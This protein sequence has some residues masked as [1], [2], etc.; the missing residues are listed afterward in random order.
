MGEPRR[1]LYGKIVNKSVG[2]EA[3]TVQVAH[4]GRHMFVDHLNVFNKLVT[5]LISV[6]EKIEENDK[7]VILASSLP[8]SWEQLVRNIL[9]IKI[10]LNFNQTVAYLLEAES[11]KK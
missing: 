11:L 6:G 4:G 10:T 2:A 7:V 8:L 5:Q 3:S 1:I 9:I